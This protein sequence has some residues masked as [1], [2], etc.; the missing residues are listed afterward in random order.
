MLQGEAR[1]TLFHV[2]V[3]QYVVRRY[4]HTKDFPVGERDI[5][6]LLQLKTERWQH[7]EASFRGYGGALEMMRELPSLARRVDGLFN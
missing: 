5:P 7:R 1:W 6:C 4:T 2:L 3:S